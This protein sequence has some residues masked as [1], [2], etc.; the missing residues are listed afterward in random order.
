MTTLTTAPLAPLLDRLFEEAVSI[1]RT[2]ACGS[3]SAH[4]K[5]ARERLEHDPEKW[6]PVFGKTMLK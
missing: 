6:K 2:P 5:R 4:Q 3:S 1:R